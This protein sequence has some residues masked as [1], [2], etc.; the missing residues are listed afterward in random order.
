[1]RYKNRVR[2]R[3]V[4]KGRRQR[5]RGAERWR[6]EMEGGEKGTL[7]GINVKGQSIEHNSIF[8]LLHWGNS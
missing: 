6:E 7:L 2:R 5:K 8:E 3:N 1:M 4:E